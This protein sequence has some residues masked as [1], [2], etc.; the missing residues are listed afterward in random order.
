MLRQGPWGQ[1]G[2][3]YQGCLCNLQIPKRDL[4]TTPNGEIPTWSLT[5]TKT[6]PPHVYLS[7]HTSDPT[8]RRIVSFSLQRSLHPERVDLS[9]L[10]GR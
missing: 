1:T 8:D 9:F 3:F 7:L 4:K 5:R 2:G 6:S 10:F